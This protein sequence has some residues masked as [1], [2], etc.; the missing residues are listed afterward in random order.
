MGWGV[1]VYSNKGPTHT[2]RNPGPVHTVNPGHSF[3]SE[4]L[5]FFPEGSLIRLES[6]GDP[7]CKNDLRPDTRVHPAGHP[8]VGAS[9]SC[10]KAS[11]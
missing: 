9:P 8:H 10:P 5:S 3:L 7:F 1:V 2:Q 4:L 11:L 6:H